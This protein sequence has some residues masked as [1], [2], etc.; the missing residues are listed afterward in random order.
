[1]QRIIERRQRRDMRNEIEARVVPGMSAARSN[2]MSMR[3]D[4]NLRSST[5]LLSVEKNS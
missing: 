5:S 3:Y 4:P 1:M 2:T